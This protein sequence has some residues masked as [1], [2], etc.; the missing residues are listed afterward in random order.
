[1][2]LDAFCKKYIRQVG[3]R[4]SIKE[5]PT[6]YSC[7]FLEGKKCSIYDVRPKQCSSYPFWEKNLASEESWEEVKKECEG[8]N[9]EAPLISLEEIRLRGS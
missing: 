3:M 4:Y 5:D 8:V 1:M 7:L 6:N 2:D 9:Q